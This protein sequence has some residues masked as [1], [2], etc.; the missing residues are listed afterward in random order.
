MSDS[1]NGDCN[2]LYLVAVDIPKL[3]KF[4]QILADANRCRY[5]YHRT[6]QSFQIARERIGGGRERKRTDSGV[7]G[8]R[9]PCSTSIHIDL[10]RQFIFIFSAVAR[11]ENIYFIAENIV[12]YG[13]NW[14]LVDNSSPFISHL[15]TLYLLS[16]QSQCYVLRH[17]MFNH[18]C[19]VFIPIAPTL[20]IWGKEEN[21]FCFLFSGMH[22]TVCRVCSFSNTQSSRR[23]TDTHSTPQKGN[24]KTQTKNAEH[25]NRNIRHHCEWIYGGRRQWSTVPDHIVECIIKWNE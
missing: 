8:Q 3:T 10:F 14:I 7:K 24:K 4:V 2:R 11:G 17:I 5:I 6:S 20:L 21:A 22:S 23:Y 13:R 25:W 16:E 9:N 19:H 12:V 18:F 1:V 15:L